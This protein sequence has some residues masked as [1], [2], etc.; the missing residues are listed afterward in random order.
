M[1][2]NFY[3][4]ACYFFY[5]DITLVFNVLISLSIGK[6]ANNTKQISNSPPTAEPFTT[7]EYIIGDIPSG[8]YEPKNTTPDIK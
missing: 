4:M 6:K 1:P 8:A 3:Y 7:K 2:Y 5:D